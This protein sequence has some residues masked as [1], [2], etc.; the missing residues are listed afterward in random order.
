[1]LADQTMLD[2]LYFVYFVL[3]LAFCQIAAKMNTL[4]RH[5]LSSMSSILTVNPNGN[6]LIPLQNFRQNSIILEA[7]M[8]LGTVE[9]FEASELK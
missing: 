9:K 1:M 8:E 7:G 4:Q 3:A 6:L 2:L 5:G